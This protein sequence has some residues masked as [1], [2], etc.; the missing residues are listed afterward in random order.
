M[1]TRT[2]FTRKLYRTLFSCL[3]S[4]LAAA[5]SFMLCN[6]CQLT[7]KVQLCSFRCTA[8]PLKPYT[9]HCYCTNTHAS[10][11]CSCS[12]ASP[13]SSLYNLVLLMFLIKIQC[14]CMCLLRRISSPVESL[15]LLT[16]IES[17]L[18]EH[19]N[20]FDQFLNVSVSEWICI[21]FWYSAIWLYA[22]T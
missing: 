6:H 1:L 7:S 16:F 21:N 11:V 19:A 15:L 18:K 14:S 12:P 2:L 3:L 20:L 10:T 5:V 8:C 9:L 4:L 17:F 22:F 13:T